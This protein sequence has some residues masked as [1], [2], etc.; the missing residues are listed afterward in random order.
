MPSTYITHLGESVLQLLEVLE[1][2]DTD[3]SSQ[4]SSNLLSTRISTSSS[5]SLI[6]DNKKNESSKTSTNTLISN[7]INNI[8]LSL[9]KT[10]GGTL[11]INKNYIPIVKSKD[12]NEMATS[13]SNAN[14]NSTDPTGGITSATADDDEIE[15]MIPPQAVSGDLNQQQQPQKSSEDN[16]NTVTKSIEWLIIISEGLLG[17]YIMEILNIENIKVHGK[18][19]LNTDISY[20]KNIFTALGL[21]IDPIFDLLSQYLQID[22][23]GLKKEIERM[24][25]LLNNNN[26]ANNASNNSENI[27]LKTELAK[28]L[29]RITSTN[30]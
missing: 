4:I 5:T 20:V 21:E 17:N 18:N 28:W 6:D 9:W 25:E 3:D 27:Q 14:N 29:I 1:P 11:G 12:D 26:T 13:P 2:L 8:N 16:K 15:E 19:Q 24:N 23:D 22:V 30:N 7:C 10:L